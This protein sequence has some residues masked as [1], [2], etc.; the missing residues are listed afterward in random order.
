MA[1]IMMIDASLSMSGDKMAMATA[2]L[3]VLAY[4]LKSIDYSIIVFDSVARVMKQLDQKVA[5]ETLVSDLLDIPVMGFTNIED[6]LRTGIRELNSAVVKDKVGIMITDG[7]YTAG[8]DPRELA[9]QYPR[10]FVVMIKSHDSKPELCK[11]VAALG[12]GKVLAVDTFEEIP[13]VLRDLLRDLA[14]R[15]YGRASFLSR[16]AS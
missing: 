14:Y 4:K 3:G 7:N 5:V 15:G 1:C 16:G 12:K 8:K 11:E 9:A 6:A 2:S 10:L 13:H